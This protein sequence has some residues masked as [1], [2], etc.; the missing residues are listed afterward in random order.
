MTLPVPVGVIGAGGHAS[1]LADYEAPLRGARIVRWAPSPCGRD[2][3]RAAAHAERVGAG[4]VP[5]WEA[6]AGDP[7][8]PAVLVASDDPEKLTAVEAALAAGKM[9]GCPAPVVTRTT[10]L[11]RLV[12]ALARG[13]GL[14]SAGM[15]R[16][17][18]AGEQA[19]RIAA[20]GELGTLHSVYVA[21]RFPAGQQAERGP[22]ILEEAGWEVFDFL[23][24]LTPAPVRRVHAH[25]GTLFGLRNDTAVLTI[26]FEDDVVAT[27]EVSRC[28]PPA[29][30]AAASGDVEV[31][32]IGSRQ[33]IRV[34]PGAAA[35]QISGTG[36]TLC[37]WVEDPVISLVEELASIAS[38][39][40]PRT[41]NL[42]LL[43][44]TVALMDAAR[45]HGA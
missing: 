42:D 18:A 8:I 36:S 10:E 31:E 44:R 24:R 5:D 22:T 21:I 38:G 29:I 19:M 26:R 13:G 27:V 37:P 34:V 45:A 1:A 4:F 16:H 41:A 17:T 39:E 3:S 28:L 2:R 12:A 40:M 7:A 32:V 9:V 35:V 30:P 15:L 25:T 33:A 20:A 14:V 43:R 6:L 11:D 23:V